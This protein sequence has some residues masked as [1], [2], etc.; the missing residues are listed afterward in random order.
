MPSEMNFSFFIPTI[1]GIITELDPNNPFF[2]EITSLF[3]QPFIPIG[4]LIAVLRSQIWRR[5]RFRENGTL[6]SSS[7]YLQSRWRSII[8]RPIVDIVLTT[9]YSNGSMTMHNVYFAKES[10]NSRQ[11][12]PI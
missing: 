1:C 6:T 8:L 12:F 5:V 4:E 11:H 2:S 3:R 7:P 9:W 10:G